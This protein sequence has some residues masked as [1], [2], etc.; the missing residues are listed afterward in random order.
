MARLQ[1]TIS[2]DTEK[3]LAL[4]S[5]YTGRTKNSLVRELLASA[6]MR[7]E[8]DRIPD[9]LLQM[10]EGGQE[11]LDIRNTARGK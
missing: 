2:D 6:L 9:E 5:A 7:F 4:Y 11:T 10:T 8:V 1:T 3:R